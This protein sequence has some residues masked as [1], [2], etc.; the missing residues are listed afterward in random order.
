MQV[1]VTTSPRGQLRRREPGKDK[2]DMRI[3]R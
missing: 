1:S 2:V 3:S